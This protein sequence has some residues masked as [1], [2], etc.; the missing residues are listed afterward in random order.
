MLFKTLHRFSGLLIKV[1]STIKVAFCK[2]LLLTSAMSSSGSLSCGEPELAQ[3][4]PPALI[5]SEQRR[6]ES[7]SCLIYLK[8]NS[9]YMN[10]MS[11]IFTVNIKHKNKCL[12]WKFQ[13]LFHLRCT[14]TDSW[15]GLMSN[16][17][18]ALSKALFLVSFD[19]CLPSSSCPMA[20]SVINSYRVKIELC[21]RSIFLTKS[22]ETTEE[23]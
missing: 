1:V 7:T 4:P 5:D 13:D 6:P 17:L 2:Y 11:Y 10:Y 21:L 16:A 8:Q 22:L 23:Y 12:V 18:C 15:P 20:T 14:Y 19:T 9:M 3:T